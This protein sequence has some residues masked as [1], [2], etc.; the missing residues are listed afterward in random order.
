[1][2]KNPPLWQLETQKKQAVF[3]HLASE[4]PKNRQLGKAKQPFLAT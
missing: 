1:M 2:T 4:L 3:R